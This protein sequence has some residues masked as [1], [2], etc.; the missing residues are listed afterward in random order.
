MRWR[1]DSEKGTAS[2]MSGVVS[3]PP[4]RVEALAYILDRI[5]RSGT[6]PSYGEIGGA[7]LPIVTKSRA[8][9][10]VNELVKLGFIERPIASRR[11]IRIRDLVRCRQAVGDALGQNG[12]SHAKPLGTLQSPP[13]TFEQLPRLRLILH[14]R[15]AS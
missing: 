2:S 9:Q 12:W 8:R 10:Y 14:K 3:A 13:C 15:E 6:S 1:H 4:R 5:E 11:G 7:M